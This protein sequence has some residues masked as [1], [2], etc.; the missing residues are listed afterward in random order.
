[1]LSMQNIKNN[2]T[3]KQKNCSFFQSWLSPHSPTFVQKF[4]NKFFC[5][6]TFKNVQFFYQ[7]SI[8]VAETHVYMKVL[9]ATKQQ[10]FCI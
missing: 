7:N 5:S 9:S 3:I 1:M 2:V 6:I 10:V 4:L 8:F